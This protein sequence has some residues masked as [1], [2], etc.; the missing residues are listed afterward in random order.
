M[1]FLRILA[2]VGLTAAVAAGCSTVTFEEPM[3]LNRRDLPR[4]PKNWRG[5]WLD[6]N[7]D[8]Y[9]IAEH[10]FTDGDSTEVYILGESNRLR[11]YRD[12]LVFNNLNDNGGWNVI[13]A[14]RRG[15]VIQLYHFD[16]SD[17]A[18]VA[19]WK[20]ELNGSDGA[21]LT[22]SG[23]AAKQSYHL[24]PENNAAWRHLVRN[25]ALSPMST[26]VKQAP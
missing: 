10:H 1:N 6:D 2:L 22:A 7:G 21:G 19:L 9:F 23:P 24:D 12:C 11:R 15:G 20:A 14:R 18:K 3:P 16:A 26:L 25:E 4:F 13:L 8:T 17:E 5:T